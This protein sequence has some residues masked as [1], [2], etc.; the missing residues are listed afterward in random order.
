MS[1]D[2]LANCVMKMLN[3]QKPDEDSKIIVDKN[4]LYAELAEKWCSDRQKQFQNAKL[5]TQ[6]EEALKERVITQ[7]NDTM[8]K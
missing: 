1:T 5:D 8:H 7:I 4:T 3:Q 2:S 6:K